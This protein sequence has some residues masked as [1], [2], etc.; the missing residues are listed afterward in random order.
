MKLM[1]LSINALRFPF[2]NEGQ[3][4]TFLVLKIKVNSLRISV[5][6]SDYYVSSS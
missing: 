4:K 1:L 3:E 5:F 6:S 2:V